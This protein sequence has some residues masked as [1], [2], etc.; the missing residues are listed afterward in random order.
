MIEAAVISAVLIVVFMSA[1]FILSLWRRDN[2]MVDVAWGI[3]FLLVALA[4]YFLSE[5]ETIRKALLTALIIVW[6]TRLALRIYLKNRGKP[7]DFRYRKWREEWGRTFVVRS[8][9]Q[10]YLL[11]GIVMFFVALPIIITNTLGG[12]T[13]LGILDFFGLS[14]WLLGFFFE[15]RGD[16]ELDRFLRDPARRPGSIMTSGLWRYT[17]HPNYFGEATMWWGLALIALSVGPYGSLAFISPVLITFLLLK[18][19]GVPMLE[20]KWAGNPGFEAYKR[21]TSVFIPWFSRQ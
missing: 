8:F 16:Y 11:Q 12:P 14:L 7:E 19:S 18:V 5:I 3:G 4:T 21:R 9:L 6:G 20:A 1:V 13:S 15:A 17:R 10:I 2:G